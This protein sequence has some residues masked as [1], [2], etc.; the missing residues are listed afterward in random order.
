M[1]WRWTCIAFW[2]MNY[3]RRPQASFI[4]SKA[5]STEQNHMHA[6]AIVSLALVVGFGMAMCF[7]HQERKARKRAVEAELRQIR[8]REES[9]HLRQQAESRQK[10]TRRIWHPSRNIGRLPF[11]FWNF[12]AGTKFR[13]CRVVPRA[14]DWHATNGRYRQAMEFL[15]FWLKS[16]NPTTGCDH[17][18]HRVTVVAGGV[19]DNAGF[20]ISTI[21]R[22]TFCRIWQSR[23]RRARYRL[24]LLTPASPEFWRNWLH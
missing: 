2:R 11:G 6:A 12:S 17:N 1:A 14:R 13:V 5:D 9:D 23:G 10:L 8:L 3:C 4:V 24:S 7:W 18:G 15:I 20:E 22:L 21:G 16:I 19:R